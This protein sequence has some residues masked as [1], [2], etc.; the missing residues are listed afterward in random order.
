MWQDVLQLIMAADGDMNQIAEGQ[1]QM[2]TATG[3]GDAD[4]QIRIAKTYY[5]SSFRTKLKERKTHEQEKW[6]F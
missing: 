2:A 4:S 5:R 1:L 3:K 6:N